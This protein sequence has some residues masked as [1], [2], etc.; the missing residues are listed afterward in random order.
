MK[1]YLIALPLVLVLG[2]GYG[3]Y[4][5]SR[6][7]PRVAPPDE[8]ATLFTKSV[9]GSEIIIR[10][11]ESQPMRLV[12][13]LGVL[14]EGYQFV[15]MLAQTGTQRIALLKNGEM[16]WNHILDKPQQA[17]DGFFQMAELSDAL[18]LDDTA[19]LLFKNSLNATDPAL[20]IALDTQTQETRWYCLAKGERLKANLPGGERA[21]YLVGNDQIYRLAAKPKQDAATYGLRQ[22]EPVELPDHL[23]NIHQLLPTGIFTFL[24]SHEGGLSARNAKGEWNHLERPANLG[25]AT[26]ISALAGTENS[27]FWQPYP[28][29]LVQVKADG[30]AIKGYGAES[31]PCPEPSA[32]DAHL[33]RL[34]GADN[35][36]ALWFTLA[37]PTQSPAIQASLET[38]ALADG[39][40]LP[41]LD[42]VSS[43]A[44]Q[45]APTTTD[46]PKMPL[47]KA[48]PGIP[49]QAPMGK[50]FS[51]EDF[52]AHASKGLDRIYR[53][54]PKDKS[55][56]A[57][58]MPALWKARQ[59]APSSGELP[60]FQPASGW[61][62]FPDGNQCRLV[63]INALQPK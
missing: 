7:A 3:V 54:Q 63:P 14:P 46:T 42:G 33:L 2:A 44:E 51:Y 19:I 17:K 35:S 21:A 47:A 57:F 9:E 40:P 37:A 24:L 26:A 43:P 48:I 32:L 61:I 62:S 50:T 31:F 10:L 59:P 28:G 22:A 39:Q 60:G 1:K 20:V 38:E 18:L 41:T 16:L 4:R 15:Q 56:K 12:R 34:K 25:P 30:T 27:F 23:Q 53:W 36:G 11:Q 55:L 29:S 52:Q 13:W 6:R 45:P 58:V 5:I 8:S 49:Q